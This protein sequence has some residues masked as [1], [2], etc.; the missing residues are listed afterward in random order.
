VEET[1]HLLS[2]EQI[3]RREGGKGR[4]EFLHSQRSKITAAKQ[5]EKKER[6]RHTTT[7]LLKRDMLKIGQG[8]RR[9]V[10]FL[11]VILNRT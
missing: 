11:C 8:E 1:S 3:Q 7:I 6:D 2:K 10:L 5:G 9:D 4:T